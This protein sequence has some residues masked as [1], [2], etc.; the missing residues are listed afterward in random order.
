MRVCVC[1]CVCA[2]CSVCVGVEVGI[3]QCHPD[4][5][6]PYTAQFGIFVRVS[7][8]NICRFGSW[9]CDH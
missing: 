3:C 9:K 6:R 5:A 4:P 1:V 7:P 8:L 2:T